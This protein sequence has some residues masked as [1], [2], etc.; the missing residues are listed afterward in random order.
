MLAAVPAGV[1]TWIGPLV[2]P[3]GTVSVIWLAE[4]TVKVAGVPPIVTEL[5]P[6]SADPLTVT[7]EPSSPLAGANPV[8]WGS[9]GAVTPTVKGSRCSRCRSGSPPGSGRS[10]RRS[11][12]S[13]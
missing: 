13:A 7:V 8:T 10:S 12:P 11:A 6:V 4:L 2:A 5:A 3:A 1:V 9:G